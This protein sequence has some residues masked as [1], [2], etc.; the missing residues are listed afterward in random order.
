MNKRSKIVLITTI[1]LVIITAVGATFAFVSLK[2]NSIKIGKINFNEMEQEN[3]VENNVQEI[4]VENEIEEN[5][6]NETNTVEDTYDY[7]KLDDKNTSSELFSKYYDKATELLKEMSMEEKVGQMFLARYPEED[8]N[9]EITEY[10][11]GGYILFARD[12]RDETVESIKEKLNE[13]QKNSKIKMFLAVD[14]EGGS[15][16]RVSGFEQF[17]EEPFKSPQT[18]FKESGLKG[19]IEDSHEKTELLKNLGINMNLTPVVDIPTNEESFIY[20]RSFGQ[21]AEETAK[22]AKQLVNTMKKDKIISSLKHFP[23]Y[24]DNVDTHTGIAIDEREYSEFEKTD[25]LPFKS[26]IESGAPTVLVN[27]NIVK[28]MDNKLPSS[29]SENVHKILR[30]K[31]EFSGIIMTDDLGMDAVKEYVDDGQAA[32]QAILAGNDLII[33]SDFVKQKSEVLNAIAE[34]KISEDLINKAVRRIL[35]CKMAYGILDF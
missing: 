17:R 11:P 2:N 26:G 27:H 8:A 4:A 31:L 24:G 1:V 13:N 19:I 20:D 23:G 33:T 25:F 28:C 30:E 6:V 34:E 35:A 22:Y 18:I 14:E 15:V 32:V 9:N 3:I 10:N 7:S 21:N 16:V 5:I 29:L 12:F